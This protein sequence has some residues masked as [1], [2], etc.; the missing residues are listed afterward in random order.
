[1][2]LSSGLMVLATAAGAGIG[3]KSIFGN[4]IFTAAGFGFL[5]KGLLLSFRDPL[6]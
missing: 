3:V 4:G 1:M 6:C 5:I 2:A